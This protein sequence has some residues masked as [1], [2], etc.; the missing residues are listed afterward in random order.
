MPVQLE[1]LPS[2]VK[3]NRITL[4]WSKPQDQKNTIQKYTVY[5]GTVNESGKVTELTEL[6]TIENSS[7]CEYLVENLERGKK[8]EF[9]VTATNKYGEGMKG[10][11]K[12]VKVKKGK[13]LVRYDID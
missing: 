8:Y 5:Q 4:K 10:Q 13:V 3:E 7:V 11:G 1:E 2:K 12:Q 6:T 9:L